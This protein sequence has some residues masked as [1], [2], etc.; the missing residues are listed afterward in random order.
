MYGNPNFLGN[1]DSPVPI[2]N[3][4]ASIIPLRISIA[5]IDAMRSLKSLLGTRQNANRLIKNRD[6][7]A[8]ISM[9][10]IWIIS[11]VLFK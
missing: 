9:R 3:D 10:K 8:D 4:N 5:V 6:S 2:L 1:T 7:P 11:F